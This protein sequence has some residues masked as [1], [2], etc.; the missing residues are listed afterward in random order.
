MMLCIGFDYFEIPQKRQKFKELVLREN[1]N[2]DKSDPYQMFR[3]TG[4]LAKIR[5]AMENMKKKQ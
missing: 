1:F 3:K 5:Q 4:F 2:A